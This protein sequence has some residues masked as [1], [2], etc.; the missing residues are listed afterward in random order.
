MSDQSSS[1]IQAKKRILIHTNPTHLKTGLG[2][3]A[4]HL[5]KYLYGTGKYI[6]GHYCSQTSVA[7]PQLRL[8][9]WQSWGC[10]PNDQVSINQLNADPSKAR[11]AAYGAWNID[12]VIKEF[13]P[14]AYLAVDDPWMAPRSA[15]MDKPWWNKINSMMHITLDSLP[16]LDQALEQA[17]LTKNY[18]TW[19]KFAA[20]EMK[21]IGPK[22]SHVRHIYAALDVDSFVP[23]S[24]TE[25]NELRKRFGIS[26]STLIFN[27]VFRNQLRKSANLI[28]DAFAQFKKD[29]PTADAKLHFHTSWSEMGNGWNLTKMME[30]YGLKK[31]DVLC[32]YVCKTCGQWH[33]AP[34]AGEE[35][36]CPY[37][38]AKKSMITATITNGVK[39]SEM[40]YMYGV[41]D[42]ALSIFTSG[43]FE[44]TS[45]QALLCGLPLACTNYFC[46]VD[47][48][49][50]DFVHSVSYHPYHEQG[51]NFI[52]AASDVRDIKRFMTKIYKT[53]KRD[54]VDIIQKGRE[55]AM[56]NFSIKTIGPQW[57]AIFDAAPQVNWDSINF[58]QDTKN[59]KFPFPNIEDNDAFITTLYTEILHMD[60]KPD[61]DGRKH[62]LARLRDGMKRE[63]IWQYFLSVA[64]Q[65]NAKI[66]PA[67]QDFWQNIDKTTGKK[68]GLFVIKQSLGDCLICTQLFE[69]FHEQYKDHD[70]YVA[71]E[72]SCTE[73]FIGNP[74][75]FKI[76][77]Y[78][79]FME[80]EMACIGSGQTEA[81]FDVY[82]HP[83]IQSQR[84]LNY[85]SN[86]NLAHSLV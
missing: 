49:E 2:E 17:S 15:Y 79:P 35:Q 26:P 53:P 65:D 76:L 52:K 86:N 48:C 71:T 51:T 33:I 47:F 14:D 32:T 29:Y 43:G 38:G 46:G 42:A 54:L 36:D 84:Q 72:P 44:M 31:E 8:T 58:T 5:L 25:K 59:D 67:T 4:R 37:C 20:D 63:D 73:M 82:M 9:P 3:N 70:L 57:E 30:Y 24:D 12:N 13:K 16:I 64:Q 83:A 60:E 6:I 56:K 74:H 78:Q 85:L 62:W 75:V 22:Y 19:V 80:Q 23:I 18:Y 28:L 34:Y 40:K 77:Q 45:A 7:D 61:G 11:D 66:A 81:L 10:L 68:R 21:R 50:Q 1:P 55:W 69:S 41:S 27:F 39:P